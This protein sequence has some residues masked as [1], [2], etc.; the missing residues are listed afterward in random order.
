MINFNEAYN[1]MIDSALDV[2]TERV[3]LFQCPGRVLMEDVYTDVS[4]PPF[5]RSAMDG[6]ACRREDLDTPLEVIEIIQAGY[7]PLKEI[8][9]G[10]CSKIMT[11]AKVPKGADMVVM[12]E[13]TKTENNRIIVVNRNSPTNIRF[14]GEDL[15]KGDLA[16][17]KGTCIGSGET[18][19]LASV[20]C[21]DPLVSKKPRV[22]II[23]TGSELVEPHCLPNEVQLRNSNSVQ[24]YSQTKSAGAEPTYYGIAPDDKTALAQVV[25]HAMKESDIVIL[26]GGVSMGDYDFVSEILTLLDVKILFEKIA[27]KPGKPTVFGVS[28]DCCFFGLPG[29]P[30]SSFVVFELMVRPF[31]AKCMGREY[32]FFK[33]RAKAAKA[34]HR[35]K[36]SLLETIP[37]KLTSDG[38]VEPSTYHGSGHIHAFTSSDALIQFQ[39]G[40]DCIEENQ[41]IDVILLP[42][43][44]V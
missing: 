11:G 23:A 1:I 25:T 21:A 14:E 3:P 12:L 5:D 33:I 16:L 6:F 8:G 42:K 2:K 19:V 38:R 9:K 17:R 36:T 4:M 26:S 30:V 15:R 29:N 31:L 40:I 24:L 32:D 28:N 34:V 35:K 18:A 10:Q 37:A 20:G 27:Q 7:V 41:E 13:H 22:G 43:N 44:N 39:I